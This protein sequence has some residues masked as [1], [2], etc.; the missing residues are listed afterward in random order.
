MKTDIALICELPTGSWTL[1]DR[2]RKEHIIPRREDMIRLNLNGTAT[3]IVEAYGQ[4]VRN[5]DD[6]SLLVSMIDTGFVMWLVN[7]ARA[8]PQS[9][10]ASLDYLGKSD[11]IIRELELA[12]Y[13]L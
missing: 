2:I 8:N 3:P 6:I 13:R 10:V 12:G 11:K 4:T 9:A 1:G 5:I 7:E